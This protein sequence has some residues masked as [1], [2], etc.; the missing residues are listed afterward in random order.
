MAWSGI[1]WGMK[2]RRKLFDEFREFINRGNVID[3]AVAVIMGAA[4]T[5]IINSIAND[6][7]TPLISLLT[8][9]TDFSTLSFT[10]VEGD[11]AAK[12]KYGS[13]IQ[14]VINFFIV[15]VVVFFIVK[16]MNKM[17]HK[18]PEPGTKD[19]S[20]CGSKIPEVAVRC[21]NCTTILNEDK[22]P[23]EVR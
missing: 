2:K 22:V 10:I 12:F 4:F 20:Y 11:N 18:K 21:P 14:A 17:S 23:E 5:A 8:F 15:A 13:L 16:T 9:G 1:I 3:L 7:I 19:C 6:L